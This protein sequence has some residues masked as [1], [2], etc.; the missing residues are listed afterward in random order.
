MAVLIS[1]ILAHEAIDQLKLS[2]NSHG[3][4]EGLF[5][6]APGDFLLYYA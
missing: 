3:L 1:A 6:I 2:K 5:L 4:M